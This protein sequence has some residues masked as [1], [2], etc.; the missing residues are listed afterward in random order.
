MKG[1]EYV[2]F[3]DVTLSREGLVPLPLA[4]GP[5]PGRG[6]MIEAT[7]QLL[8]WKPAGILALTRGATCPAEEFRRPCHCRTY[9]NLPR[10]VD[11]IILSI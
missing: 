7:A 6:E 1:A 5:D 9:A 3:E 11:S 4:Y 10:A 8:R 2:T